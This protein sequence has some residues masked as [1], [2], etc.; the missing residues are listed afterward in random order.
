MHGKLIILW[1]CSYKES[2]PLFGN[3]SKYKKPFKNQVLFQI[4]KVHS[5][6]LYPEIFSL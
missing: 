4:K 2:T 5:I 3:S 1:N 6:N